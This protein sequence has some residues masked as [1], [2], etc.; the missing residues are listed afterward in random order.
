MTQ[1]LTNTTYYQPS[2]LIVLLDSNNKIT[3]KCYSQTAEDFNKNKNVVG[4]IVNDDWTNK[5]AKVL[6]ITKKKI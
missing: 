3:Y 1:T 2:K 4:S 6:S 5:P